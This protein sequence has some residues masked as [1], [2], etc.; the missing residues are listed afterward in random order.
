MS[1]VW[2]YV[3]HAGCYGNAHGDRSVDHSGIPGSPIT[4]AAHGAGAAMSPLNT[5]SA[6]PTTG[7]AQSALPPLTLGRSPGSFDAEDG[8]AH[9]TGP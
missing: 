8:K 5:A 4:G 3:A 2:W 9:E 6:P 7:R 1:Q